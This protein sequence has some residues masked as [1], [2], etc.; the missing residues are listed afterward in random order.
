M[1]IGAVFDSEWIYWDFLFNFL[2][3]PIKKALEYIREW[4]KYIQQAK[5]RAVTL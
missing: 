2:C 3:F 5:H 1:E 4:G